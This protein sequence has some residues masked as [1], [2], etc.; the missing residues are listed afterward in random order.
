MPMTIATTVPKADVKCAQCGGLLQ[1]DQGQV[2]LNCPYCG[3]AVYLDRSRVVFHWSLASTFTP[4]AAAANLR[5][6]MAGN[7]TVKD[8]DRKARVTASSF[9]YFP[10]WYCK[11]RLPGGKEQIY[12][13]PAAAT[14]ISE[15]KSL[16]IPAG[17]L[18]KYDSALDS[19]AV[20]PTVP[21]P[22]MQQWLAGRG[23][24]AQHIAEAALVHLPIYTFKYDFG[25][26]S[27]TA[28]VEGA[29]GKVFANIFPAKAEAPYMVVAAFSTAGF[30]VLSTLPI[31]GFFLG[32]LTGAALGLVACLGLGAVFAVP[33]FVL[34]AIISAKV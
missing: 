12:L 29:S 24:S 28:V 27:Y 10:V 2:F 17:D 3:S 14:S 16:V 6:W 30:L 15:I 20:A 9:N 34:A 25:G 5:R 4:E 8:L 11:A 19:Q 21:Y 13:E 22:A 23:V 33:V 7:Q 31:A 32:E 18:Q 26:Q 1:P